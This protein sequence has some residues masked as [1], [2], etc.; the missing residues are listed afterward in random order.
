MK[1]DIR[2]RFKEVKWTTEHTLSQDQLNKLIQDKLERARLGHRA[3][4]KREIAQG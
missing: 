3:V 1:I 2:K 4:V